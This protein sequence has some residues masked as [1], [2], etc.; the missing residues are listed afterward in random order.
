M[1]PP[2]CNTRT[3]H[4]LPPTLSNSLRCFFRALLCI[5]NSQTLRITI[6]SGI[7]HTSTVF[8]LCLVAQ[9]GLIAI[10]RSLSFSFVPVYGSWYVCFAVAVDS[11]HMLLFCLDIVSCVVIVCGLVVKIRPRVNLIARRIYKNITIRKE[12]SVHIH[13]TEVIESDGRV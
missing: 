2:I 7:T 12:T 5:R 13:K 9:L 11:Y 6:I 4:P 10:V 8:S 1:S 3:A